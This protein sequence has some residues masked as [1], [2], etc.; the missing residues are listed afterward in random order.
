MQLEKKVFVVTGGGNGIGRE[1]ALILLTKGAKVIAIDKDEVGLKETRQLAGN[2]SED[3]AAYTLDVTD[4]EAVAVLPEHFQSEYGNVDGLINDAGTIQSFVNIN[5]LDFAEIERVM[6]NNFYGMVYMTKA[7]LPD[8]L[9][10]PEALIVNFSSMGGFLPVPGQGVYGASKAAVK[11]FTEALYAEL[12]ST[13]VQVSLVFPGAV[14]TNIAANSGV[15]IDAALAEKGGEKFK[16]MP[17]SQAAQVIVEGIEKEKYHI[18]LG[19]DAKFMNILCRLA[20]KFAT[21]YIAKQMA[22]LLG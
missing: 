17:P 1:L 8:L 15:L 11:L 12:L 21:K 7:F 19:S 20:P 4:F 14:N 6:D 5:A 10:R 16:P 18:F 13:N 9:Q 2:F 3:F 22:L